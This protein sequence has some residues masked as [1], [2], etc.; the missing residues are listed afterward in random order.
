VNLGGQP[1]SP[2]LPGHILG[3]PSENHAAT[4]IADHP[5]KTINAIAAKMNKKRR[6]MTQSP[7][8]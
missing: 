2:T 5:M 3:I 8:K 7:P 6:I 1:L 4:C